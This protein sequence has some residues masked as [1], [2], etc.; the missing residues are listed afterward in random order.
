MSKLYNSKYEII[1]SCIKDGRFNWET[2]G[3][4]EFII[5][6][7]KGQRYFI[8]R[9]TMGPRI[10]V[11]TIPEPEYSKQLW[12]AKWLEEKQSEIRKNMSAIS[13]EKDHIVK[14]EENFWDKDNLFTT[15][16]KLIPGENSGVDYTSLDF[17]VFGKLCLDIA[18]LIS[19]IH[20]AGV[21]HGD[22]KE[23]NILVQK[24]GEE[25]IPYLIDFDSSYPSDYPL[26]KKKD[27]KPMY[28]YPAV[29]SDG[30]QSPEIAIYNFEEEGVVDP[31]IIT[32]K[33]DIFTLALVFHKLWTNKFPAVIGD[34][35]GV[36]DAVYCETPVQV[37]PKFSVSLGG[38]YN[39][40]FS[41]LLYWMMAKDADV[42]PTAEEVME[43]LTGKIDVDERYESPEVGFSYNTDPWKVHETFLEILTKEELK[44]K[45]VSSFDKI[46]DGGEY[47]YL[48]IM[49][50]GTEKRLNAE[51]VIDGGYGKLKNSPAADI[52]KEDEEI[53]ELVSQDELSGMG[54]VSIE[55]KQAAYRKFYFITMKTGN[56]ITT[57]RKGLVEYGYA[58]YKIKKADEECGISDMDSPWPLHG[59]AYNKEALISRNI[60]KVEKV[61]ENDEEKYLITIKDEKGKRQNI[62]KLAYMKIMKFIV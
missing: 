7:Y 51:E 39:C 26:R 25:L 62:V 42:R 31:S 57:G 4:G 21:I 27:G 37:D 33:T 16:T 30:Y 43:A 35:C 54:V 23:K 8:K 19:K 13:T 53:I 20:K 59:K 61:T 44:E 22:L 14:E 38:P 41:S 2:T 29:Y 55:K 24:K 10:P 32:D 50:D 28:P 15:V 34:C 52:W 58:R 17:T 11:K 18:E 56:G 12:K 45:K 60:I 49:K 3:N 5:G 46:T 40:K 47:K 36:G 9:Y 6:E 48:V 1:P